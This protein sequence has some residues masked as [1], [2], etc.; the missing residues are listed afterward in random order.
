VRKLKFFLPF[1]SVMFLSACG[2]HISKSAS[3][4]SDSAP[5]E[6]ASDSVPSDGCNVSELGGGMLR[7]ASPRDLSGNTSCDQDT[8]AEAL[9]IYLEKHSSLYARNIINDNEGIIRS[10]YVVPLSIRK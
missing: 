8:S 7:I 3:A 10:A 1:V 5:E 6:A 4:S 9:G 2:D